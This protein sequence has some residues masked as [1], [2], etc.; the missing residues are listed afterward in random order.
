V[1]VCTPQEATALAQCFITQQNCQ[2]PINP[3]CHACAMSGEASPYSSALLFNAANQPSELNVEGCVAALSGD[4]SATGCGP[5][6]QARFACAGNACTACTDEA[7]R[8]T[9]LQQA[10]TTTCSTVNQA[11]ACAT[12]YLPQ[13][14]QGNTELEVAF[15]LVRIFCGP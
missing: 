3:A 14:V 4:T 6:L 9:C 13:C 7:Q 12:P 1:N 8:T 15:N 5:K 10:D 11:A 2:A